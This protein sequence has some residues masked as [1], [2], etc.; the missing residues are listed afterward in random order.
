MRFISKIIFFYLIFYSFSINAT[1]QKPSIAFFILDKNNNNQSI[2][3]SLS[4]HLNQK[5]FISKNGNDHYKEILNQDVDS[6]QKIIENYDLLNQG[7]TTELF[8][9]VKLNHQKI[10]NRKSKMYISSDIFNAQTKNLINSWS[11]PIKIL[12]V[13]GVITNIGGRLH[14]RT[15]QYG[16]FKTNPCGKGREESALLCGESRVLGMILYF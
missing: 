6:L 9:I 8:I 5:G 15:R 11:S 14:H 13:D 10:N 4:S 16:H 7:L 2:I 12:K 1:E 3:L